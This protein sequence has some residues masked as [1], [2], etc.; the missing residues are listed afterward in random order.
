ML[1][2]TT[3]ATWQ[4][5]QRSVCA[6]MAEAGLTAAV[7]HT[8]RLTRGKTVVDV[9]ATENVS[10]RERV[11][12]VEYKH[13]KARVPQEVVRGFRTTLADAGADVGYV[14][15]KAGFQAGALEAA[16]FTNVRLLT[17]TE[18]QEE[19]EPAWIAYHLLPTVEDKFRRL[20]MSFEM[21]HK[22]PWPPTTDTRIER[23]RELHDQYFPFID[24][25]SRFGT[26]GV[27]THGGRVP[28]LPARA[29]SIDDAH[30]IPSGILDATAY[31]D[32][33]QTALAYGDGVLEEWR[34]YSQ[35]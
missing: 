14:V 24:L 27:A 22:G 2:T 13:W 17:W 33:L 23:W 5:L 12:L 20:F 18:F 25:M 32:F 34:A 7:E 19:F 9:Y 31:R 1:T 11:V 30:L 15:S 28:R 21:P 35:L 8:V 6:I 26:I 10:G 4:D 3:P 16:K 29:L